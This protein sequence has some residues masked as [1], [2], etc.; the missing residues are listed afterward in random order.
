MADQKKTGNTKALTAPVS[1]RFTDMVVKEF[2]GAAGA[3]TLTPYQ[4]KLAQHMFIK[5]DTQL[6]DLEAKRIQSKKNV[7]S[8]EWANVNMEK[9]AIDTVHRVELGLDPLIPNH[10]SPIPYFNGKKKKYDMDLRIGFEGKNYYRQ[11]MALDVPID[12]IYELV[13]DSDEFVPMKKNH[14]REYDTYHFA[15]KN[16][17]SRGKIIGGFG[18]MIFEE[19][20]KNI[21]VIVTEADFKKSMNAAMSKDFWTKHPEK[22]R[23]KTLIHR[24]TDY[25]K[26]DPEKVNAGFFEAEKQSEEDAQGQDYL[27]EHDSNSE[28]IEMDQ[29]P[30]PE[31]TENVN[32]HEMS[33]EEKDQII[34]NEQKQGGPGMNPGF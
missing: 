15:I 16:P 12:V 1:A 22:M 10:I 13:Y 24:T 29:E 33:Q 31:T 34:A 30:E 7:A 11:K 20:I 5:V 4:K 27:P 21:L 9:L 26:V 32:S 14:E 18:Y 8:Y 2:S 28:P 25:L 3:L 23:M 6:K 17:F 19:R